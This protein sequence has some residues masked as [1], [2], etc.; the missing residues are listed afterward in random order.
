MAFY[1]IQYDLISGNEIIYL[2]DLFVLPEYR[3][4]GKKILI[5]K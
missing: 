4:K 3:N 2:E 1:Y 5:N